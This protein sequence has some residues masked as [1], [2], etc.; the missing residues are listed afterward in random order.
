MDINKIKFKALFQHITSHQKSWQFSTVNTR[1]VDF[2]DFRQVSEWLQ[3]SGL[4]DKDGHEIYEGD[5]L[6]WADYVVEVVVESGSFKILN[7][8]NS[9][10]LLWYCVPEC[11]VIGNKY[12]KEVKPRVQS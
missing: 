3:F 7:D 8:G 1:N 5:L 4:Y 12:N 11:E 2:L 9:D 10:M 6:Q